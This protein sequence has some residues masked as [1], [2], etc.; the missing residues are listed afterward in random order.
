MKTCASVLSDRLLDLFKNKFKLVVEK[1]K[2]E[3]VC[4]EPIRFD[5][6]FEQPAT[7]VVIEIEMKRE[8][9]LHNVAKTLY[10]AENSYSKKRVKMVHLFEKSFFEKGNKKLQKELAIYIGEISRKIAKNFEYYSREFKLPKKAIRH[11]TRYM[12]EIEEVANR[13]LEECFYFLK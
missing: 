3:Y 4:G 9:P 6:F 2:E 8:N 5:L 13:I 7:V 12:K 11:P 1:E 10:W